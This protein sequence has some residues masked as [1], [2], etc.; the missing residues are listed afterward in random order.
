MASAY[1]QR[2][3]VAMAH[4]HQSKQEA[5]ERLFEFYTNKY[6]NRVRAWRQVFDT[7]NEGSITMLRFFQSVRADYQCDV[8]VKK[9]WDGLVPTSVCSRLYLEFFAPR[10]IQVLRNL[11]QLLVQ[12]FESSDPTIVFERIR[13]EFDQNGDGEISQYE[14]FQLL[15]SVQVSPSSIPEVSDLLLRWHKRRPRRDVTVEDLR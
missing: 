13:E 10:E 4:A 6:G 9:A 15:S 12:R 1:A 8:N 7:E 5:V 11:R 2:P 14:I 3:L